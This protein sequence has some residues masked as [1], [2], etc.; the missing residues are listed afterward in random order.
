M[1]IGRSQEKKGCAAPPD[2]Q[3]REREEEYRP[4][5]AASLQQTSRLRNPTNRYALHLQYLLWD[6]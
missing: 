5:I 3:G 6:A 2:K 4:K 1:G